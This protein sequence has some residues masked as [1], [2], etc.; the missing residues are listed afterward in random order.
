MVTEFLKKPPSALLKL[1]LQTKVILPRTKLASW[2]VKKQTFF[3]HILQSIIYL[4]SIIFVCNVYSFKQE[5][6]YLSC[7]SDTNTDNSSEWSASCFDRLPLQEED[8]VSTEYVMRM[9]LR[10]G[11]SDN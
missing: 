7:L 10:I 9:W 1:K 11:S 3:S 5:L 8:P 4:R 2:F 6:A